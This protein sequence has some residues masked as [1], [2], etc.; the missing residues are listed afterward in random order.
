VV[1]LAAAAVV[2]NGIP[3]VRVAYVCQTRGDLADRGSPVDRFE[4]PVGAPAQRLRQSV[5]IVLVV[6]EAMRFLAGVALGDRMPL[7]SAQANQMPPSRAAE[8]DL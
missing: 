5:G 4:R 7:V 6:V 1:T 2:E 8:L 3:A